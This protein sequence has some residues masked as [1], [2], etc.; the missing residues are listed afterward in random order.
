MGG[1]WRKGCVRALSER[2]GR[3]AFGSCVV[4]TGKSL[5]NIKHQNLL[6]SKLSQAACQYEMFNIGRVC[7]MGDSPTME[8]SIPINHNRHYTA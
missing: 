3:S 4:W 2:G 5:C 6:P 7:T 8:C 1:E